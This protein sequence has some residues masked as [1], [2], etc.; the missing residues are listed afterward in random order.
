MAGAKK[1]MKAMRAMKAKRGVSTKP[2]T[3]VSGKREPL[4]QTNIDPKAVTDASMDP[5]ALAVTDA[6]K[7]AG[8][9]NAPGSA[10][11]T[12]KPREK[13]R[14]C[15]LVHHSRPMSVAFDLQTTRKTVLN[16]TN[17]AVTKK[18]SLYAWSANT[19]R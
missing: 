5:K 1:S 10:E 4:D 16:L 3:R 11:A 12:E 17:Q 15:L 7:E 14:L 18:A 9:A 2:K 8:E 6:T 13:K 19:K